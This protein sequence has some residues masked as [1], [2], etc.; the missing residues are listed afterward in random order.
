MGSKIRCFPFIAVASMYSSIA[1]CI[2]SLYSG[3]SSFP[4]EDLVGINDKAA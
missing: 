3:E 4:A 2:A 1:E